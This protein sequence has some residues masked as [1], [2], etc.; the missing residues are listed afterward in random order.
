MR[1]SF[2]RPRI[3]ARKTEFTCAFPLPFLQ[4]TTSFLHHSITTPSEHTHSAALSSLAS[5]DAVICK[6]P[7][8]AVSYAEQHLLSRAEKSI[9]R[10]STATSQVSRQ[11]SG[12]PYK[13]LYFNAM[14]S[15]TASQTVIT[16]TLRLPYSSPNLSNHER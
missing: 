12:S 14:Y 13:D 2:F 8:P 3:M 11:P 15:F 10:D 6:R 7:I 4:M 16:A 9:G 5:A 1:I